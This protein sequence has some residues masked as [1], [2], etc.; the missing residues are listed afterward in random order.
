MSD[1]GMTLQSVRDLV[2]EGEIIGDGSFFCRAVASLG[3]AQA[4]DL[5]FVSGHRHAAEARQSEAGALILSEPL[6]GAAANQIVVANP[7][8]AMIRVLEKIASEKRTEPAGIHPSAVIEEGALLGEDVSIGAGAV[9][10]QGASIGDRTVI[11]ANVYIGRRSA[12]GADC[13]IEPSVVIMEDVTL[14]ERV[15][16]HGGTV[17]GG[18]GYGFVQ[19]EGRHVKIPQVGTIEIGDD[20]EI[21]ALSTV[22]RAALDSTVIG[23]GTKIGD[24]CHVA[25]NCIVGE[26]VLILPI[27]VMGGSCKIGDHAIMAARSGLPDNITLGEGAVLAGEAVAYK[28]VEPGAV[29]WGRPARPKNQQMRIEVALGSLP[30]MQRDLRAIKKKLAAG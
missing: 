11:L 15:H 22:D 26:D 2:G 19:L 10:R 5:S 14:G 29:V 3:K 21:G 1:L 17:I 6:D 25:H 9:I 12:L 20:V 18:D 30:Q 27:S 8:L 23:R 28:D 24:L 13:L 7:F 16:I 4:G